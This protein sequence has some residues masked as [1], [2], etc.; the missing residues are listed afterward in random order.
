LGWPVRIVKRLGFKGIKVRDLD[1]VNVAGMSFLNGPMTFVDAPYF[2]KVIHVVF[3]G[4]HFD[5]VDLAN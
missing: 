2:N 5:F 4:S 3:T 1:Y